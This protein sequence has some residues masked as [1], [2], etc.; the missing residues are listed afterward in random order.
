M[1]FDKPQSE[2]PDR[3]VLS[4]YF[5]QN[6]LYPEVVGSSKEVNPLDYMTKNYPPTIIIHGTI[7]GLSL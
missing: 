6:G 7:I 1:N 3:F 4:E 2:P 5:M